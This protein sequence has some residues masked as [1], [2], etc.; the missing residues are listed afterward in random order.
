MEL[1]SCFLGIAATYSLIRAVRRKEK[2]CWAAYCLCVTACFYT[3]FFAILVLLGLNLALVLYV[4]KPP[5]AWFVAHAMAV[6]LWLPWLALTAIRAGHF[7]S[8]CVAD[9]GGSSAEGVLRLDAAGLEYGLTANSFFAGPPSVALLLVALF[10][11][12]RLLR[13]RSLETRM[14]LAWA[15]VPTVILDILNFLLPIYQVRYFLIALPGWIAVVVLGFS[16]MRLRRAVPVRLAAGLGGLI[17][18]A[19]SAAALVNYYGDPHYQRDDYRSAFALIKADALPDEALVY[20]PIMQFTAVDFYGAGLSTPAV[21]LPVPLPG[22]LAVAQIPPSGEDKTA[23]DAQLAELTQRYDGFWLLLYGDVAQWTENWLDGHRTVVADRWFGAVRLKHYRPGPMAA[24][25]MLPNGIRVDEEL[26]R[27]G[28]RRSAPRASSRA[29]PWSWTR[30]G[31]PRAR[32]R[33]TTPCRFQ[34]GPIPS[35][36][37]IAQT[38]GPPL[39]GSLPTS[40][41]T[42]DQAYR[43]TVS[44]RLPTS[45]VAR[46]VPVDGKCLR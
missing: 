24:P 25:G 40:S 39:Q 29:S 8:D 9:V 28:W 21:G 46:S 33:R 13:R 26:A 23:T 32:R 11:A 27:C 17:F 18:V 4:H 10:A 43:D 19:G 12:Y 44:L 30:D 14:L 16:D 38:D 2:W 1:L 5:R 36:Q 37:R 3:F 45:L 35:G 31:G 42:A 15:L 6:L 22:H 7:L 41:W 20:D 34:A